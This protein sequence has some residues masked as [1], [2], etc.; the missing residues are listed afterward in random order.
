[1]TV[2][3][4]GSTVVMVTHNMRLLG[5]VDKIMV[6]NEGRIQAMGAREDVLAS[7]RPKTVRI[8]KPKAMPVSADGGGSTPIRRIG[9]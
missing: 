1:M 9:A 2:K 3:E 6:L 4:W 8:S 5:P 7:L